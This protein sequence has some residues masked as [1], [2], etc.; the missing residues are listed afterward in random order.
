M[1]AASIKL[2]SE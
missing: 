2:G 1:R